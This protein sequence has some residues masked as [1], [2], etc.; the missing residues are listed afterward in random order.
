MEF[1]SSLAIKLCETADTWRRLIAPVAEYVAQE[2]W[3]SISRPTS[4]L[5]RRVLATRLTQRTRRAVKGSEV[6]TSKNPKPE[7]V[8]T[9]CGVPITARRSHCPNCSIEIATERLEH[10]A[11]VG[12][13]A[14]RP[15]KLGQNMSP[16]ICGI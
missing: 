9:D 2:I 1:V 13:I 6:T 8:C 12:R 14:A 11:Q 5:A 4:G 16:H 10:V 15:R 7:H 3:S